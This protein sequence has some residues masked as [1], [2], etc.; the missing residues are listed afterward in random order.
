VQFEQPADLAAAL[1]EFIATA[2]ARTAVPAV[3]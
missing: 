2:Q 3:P 1:L